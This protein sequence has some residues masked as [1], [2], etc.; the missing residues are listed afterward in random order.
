MSFLCKKNQLTFLTRQNFSRQNLI[1]FRQFYLGTTVWQMLTKCSS[2]QKTRTLSCGIPTGRAMAGSGTF[3]TPAA[4]G[5]N[6]IAEN[7]E[8]NISK[9][10]NNFRF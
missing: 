4:P 6:G 3:G 7:L 2:E 5:G 9:H 8:K 1:D 10:T